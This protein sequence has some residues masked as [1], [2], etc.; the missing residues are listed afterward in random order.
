MTIHIVCRH[1]SDLE[2]LVDDRIEAFDEA[3]DHVAEN[4]E[5]KA[6]FAEVA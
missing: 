3:L 2:D 6:S 4:P 1:C 5:H